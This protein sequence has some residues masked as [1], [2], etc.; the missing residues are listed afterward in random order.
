[1]KM[2]VKAGEARVE[3]AAK[4]VAG[5]LRFV[6]EVTDR[7]VLARLGPRGM[8]AITL[9]PIAL[10]QALLLKASVPGVALLPLIWC[11]VCYY[12]LRFR[13]ARA[14]EAAAAGALLA[15]LAAPP[16]T[17]WWTGVVLF[18]A[19]LG[20]GVLRRWLYAEFWPAYAFASALFA[21][22]VPAVLFFFGLRRAEATFGAFLV[23]LLLAPL[24]GVVL[25]AALDAARR[26]LGI[27]ME[28]PEESEPTYDPA[29]LYRPFTARGAG[30]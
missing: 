14:V 10:A 25:F 4:A 20:C 5:L 21:F 11:S 17:S 16:G 3:R 28:F 29:Y 13:L 18:A 23:T 27:E 1:M 6:A 24:T 12:M 8:V 15:C 26:R 22:A 2:A 7:E 30:I 19:A 9:P